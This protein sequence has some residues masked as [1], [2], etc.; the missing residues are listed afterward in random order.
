[1]SLAALSSGNPLISR[2]PEFGLFW[3]LDMRMR[4]SKLNSQYDAPLP[5]R[6]ARP[7]LL[8]QN[9]RKKGIHG[10]E[11]NICKPLMTKNEGMAESVIASSGF[12]SH[13]ISNGYL[14]PKI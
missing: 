13:T 1:M 10:P 8:R 12:K 5:Q 7:K 9:T 3:P 2:W 11:Y 14:G 4:R 6:R